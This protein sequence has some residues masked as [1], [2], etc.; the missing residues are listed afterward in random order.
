MPRAYIKELSEEL[1]SITPEQLAEP[2]GEF[3]P[4]DS[5]IGEASDEIKRIYT[6][7]QNTAELGIIGYSK[8]LRLQECKK[9]DELKRLARKV[10]ILDNLLWVSINKEFNL[11]GKSSVGIRKGFIIVWRDRKGKKEEKNPENCNGDCENCKTGDALRSV[12]SGE[13]ISKLLPLII[14]SK[15][16]NELKDFGKGED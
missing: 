14:L 16:A 3:E 1:G 15:L 12:V 13:G 8:E 7:K 4:D 9:L 10:E 5:A 6:L 11:W 2:D